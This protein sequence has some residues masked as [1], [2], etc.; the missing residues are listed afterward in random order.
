MVG[1]IVN[2]P[3]RANRTFM[4]LFQFLA[5]FY[6]AENQTVL[7]RAEAAAAAGLGTKLL[8]TVGLQK[9]PK[10]TPLLFFKLPKGQM[11][12]S[13]EMEV[14]VSQIEKELNVKIQRFDIIRDRMAR[15][16]YD[17]IDELQ[18]VGKAPLLYHRESLQTIYG[19]SSKARVRAWA[20]GRWLP[21]E[22]EG[23]TAGDKGINFMPSREDKEDFME[24]EEYMMEE[25]L[26]E[27]Q[28]MGREKMRQRME[29]GARK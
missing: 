3:P 24:D 14:V 6:L 11:E 5:V 23:G 8:Q 4:L 12:A 18:F 26:T 9:K 1:H 27:L 28:Q 2:K 20:K 19:M 29:D 15:K 22:F 10:Y 7:Y 25:D 21:R 16:L 17:K 13:D